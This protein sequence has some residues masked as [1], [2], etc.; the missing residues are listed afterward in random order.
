MKHDEEKIIINRIETFIKEYK[1]FPS[2]NLLRK[3]GM[4][5]LYHTISNNGDYEK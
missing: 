2:N 1:I 4:Y 3:L 5:N